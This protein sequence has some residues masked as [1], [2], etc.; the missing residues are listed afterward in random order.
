MFSYSINN[1]IPPDYPYYNTLFI[2]LDL[3]CGGRPKRSAVLL[4]VVEVVV[5]TLEREV[6][7]WL[8]GSDF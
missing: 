6:L 3:A 8:R 2:C 4:V 7:P 1:A 5:L